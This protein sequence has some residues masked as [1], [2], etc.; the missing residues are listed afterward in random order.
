MF[1][2]SHLYTGSDPKSTGS[3]RLRLRNTDL[4]DPVQLLQLPGGSCPA[5]TGSWQILSSCYGY[6]AD[7]VL[8]LRLPDGSCPAVTVTWRILSS[9]WR[10]K[11]RRCRWTSSSAAGSFAASSMLHFRRRHQTEKKTTELRPILEN[12]IV[13]TP[14]WFIYEIPV[15]VQVKN[16]KRKE[17]W[18]WVGII[19]QTKEG[20]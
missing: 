1:M 19:T 15:P 13:D 20:F 4:G 10:G 3:D 6:L 16:N 5:A 17:D 18:R 11:S 7:P 2:P 9:C 8:L 12:L 14:S